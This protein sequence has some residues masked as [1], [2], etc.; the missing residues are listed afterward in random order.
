MQP[1]SRANLI[2]SCDQLLQACVK[3]GRRYFGAVEVPLRD[4]E[5]AVMEPTGPGHWGGK[6]F[7]HHEIDISRLHEFETTT[8]HVSPEWEHVKETV[9]S[10]VDEKHIQPTGIFPA[11]VEAY[12]MQLFRAYLKKV[13][14]FVYRKNF[15]ENIIE[16]LLFHLDS[17]EPEV[18]GLIILEDFSADQPFKLMPNME[19]RPISLED[20]T[21]LGRTD[22]L[23]GFG[24]RR[25][26]HI[27]RTDW[28]VCEVTFPNP[29]G[30]Y[31]G[32]NK[33]HSV[34]DQLAF[35]L[36]TFKSGGL[37]FGLGISKTVGEF[38]RVPGVRGGIL[39]KIAFA[40]SGYSLSKNETT[41]FRR[42]WQQFQGVMEADH[43]YLQVRI[44]RLRSAG[45]R[46]ETEDALVDYVV[47]LEALL[48]KQEER[49]ELG[50]RFRVRGSV[51]LARAR[52]N[53]KE[54]LGLLR[55]LYDL[56]SK[57]V[58]G[59]AKVDHLDGLTA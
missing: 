51:L 52:I 20:L 10:Y 31:I 37:S 59:G 32:F 19:I 23:G 24:A 35:A 7:I 2:V 5:I 43:H 30:S 40:T 9:Q 16:E 17:P 22:T 13:G 25:F 55:D 57:I 18:R 29:R 33:M 54:Y 34:V 48:G 58:K 49:T 50:Y 21:E 36:R 28:W 41:R 1:S 15:A 8:L 44:R 53:R 46:A 14:R 3:A 4:V 6:T 45:T 42:F 47:G 39:N 12:Q 38:G 27:P 11:N 56:R 26:E